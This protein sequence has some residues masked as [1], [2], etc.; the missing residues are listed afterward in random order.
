MMHSDEGLIMPLDDT[1][2]HFQYARQMATGH[3]FEYN[4]GDEPTSGATSLLYTPLLALGYTLGFT[5]LA[6]AY[7]ALALGSASFVISAWL[8]YLSVRAAGGSR[9]ISGLM[10][11]TFALNGALLWAALSGMETLLFVFSALLCLI[12][13]QRGWPRAAAVVGILVALVRPEGAILA[14]SLAA[15]L[16]WQ[17]WQR[18]RTITL[19]SLGPV[20]AVGVQPVVNLVLTGTWAATGNQAKSELY[21]VSLPVVSRLERVLDHWMRMWHEFFLGRAQYGDPYLPGLVFVLALA[22]IAWG[23]RYSW[24]KRTIHPAL[25]AGLWIVLLSV[26]V[27]TLEVAFWHYKRYQLPIM[28][29]TIPLAGWCL[30]ALVNRFGHARLVTALAGIILLMS[31]LTN[32]TFAP[33]YANNVLVTSSFQLAIAQWI[34]GHLPAEAK[35]GVFDVGIMRYVGDRYTY[36]V[37]GLTTPD[38][39]GAMRQGSGAVYDTMASH[40]QRPD[41][42][43]LYPIASHPTT[44]YLM[45]TSV[46]GRELAR[47][48]APDVNNTTSAG[49]TQVIVAADWSGITLAAQP[50]DPYIRGYLA[51]Y[52][53]VGALNI[54]DLAAEATARYSWHNRDRVPGYLATVEELPYYACEDPSCAI[55]DG[56]RGINGWEEFD[57]PATA[58]GQNYLVVLRAKAQTAAHLEYGC[59]ESL[60]DLVI[61]Q[62]EGH[63]V[64]IAF[65]VPGTEGRLCITANGAYYPARY[66][67]YAGN[68][69]AESPPGETPLAIWAGLILL[70]YS[71]ELTPDELI[72]HTSWFVPPDLAEQLAGDGKLFVHLYADNNP[73][74]VPVTQWDGYLQRCTPVNN[75]LPGTFAEAI[76]LP[77]AGIPPGDYLIGLGFYDQQT[78]A[79]Y[80]LQ[81]QY[82]DE[83]GQRIFLQTLTLP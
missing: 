31:A 27:A 41:Y 4:T 39:A 55:L 15:A 11:F 56:V 17:H 50:H 9:W 2:I 54:G 68:A 51:G 10:M 70:D 75:L 43:V 64:D 60:G 29:L 49:P 14:V 13:F 46:W 3:P 26:A 25:L 22:S 20:L 52:E 77:L 23:V 28:A 80:P 76:R 57:L 7:W 45:R 69:V 48:E 78:G 18:Q 53:Q 19:W 37:V 63:W 34:N 73:N 62:I 83:V 32:K 58:P 79:R 8:V 6:L 1:Y 67:F 71:L 24:R 40:P 82:T 66:W 12:T 38:I 65:L 16:A 72:V 21:D 61:P 42:F 47:F 36:D 59:G 5:D 30:T 81:A 74:Q 33:L 35:L 44:I